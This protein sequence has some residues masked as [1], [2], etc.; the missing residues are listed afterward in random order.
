MEKE[1]NFPGPMLRVQRA[2]NL[3]HVL[4]I[5]FDQKQGTFQEIATGQGTVEQTL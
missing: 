3:Y 5:S 2:A 4:R 1:T